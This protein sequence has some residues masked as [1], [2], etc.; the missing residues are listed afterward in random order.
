M[1]RTR[2]ILIALVVIVL[3]VLIALASIKTEVPLTHIEEP[4]TNGAQAQ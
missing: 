3:L 4:V 1:S 2:I